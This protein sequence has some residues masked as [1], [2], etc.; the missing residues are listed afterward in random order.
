MS[1]YL[2]GRIIQG[3]LLLVIVSTLTF[4]VI[5]AAPGGPAMLADPD[6]SREEVASLKEMLGL[7]API[8][9]QYYKWA[10]N[11]LTGK[12][13]RSYSYGVPVITLLLERLPNTLLL[14][15][16]ALLLSSILAIPLGI[17]AALRRGSTIDHMAVSLSIG[18]VAVPVFWLGIMLIIVFAVT[19]RWFPTGGIGTLGAEFSIFD[20]LHHLALPAFVLST[21]TTAQLAR[22]TRS[23]VINTLSEDYVRT[24]RA[25][26]VLESRVIIW[27]VFRNSLIPII[28]VLGTLVPR[29]V[30]GAAITEAIFTWPG[31]GRLAV[32]AAFERDYPIIM[33]VTLFICTMVIVANIL[34]DI[35]YALIDPRVVVGNHR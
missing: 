7:D 20:L 28:T 26:G 34:V 33:G 13:G 2:G 3:V 30:G 10:S 6:L 5:H 29:L 18:G 16:S 17:W 27:H 35:C 32:E 21:P 9:V 23:S 12:L 1:S 24:A 22:Y 8:H 14:S 25:K 15:G 11:V 31:V 19:L 4:L